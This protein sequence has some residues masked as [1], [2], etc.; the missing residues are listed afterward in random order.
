MFSGIGGFETALN[1]LGGNCV[2]ASEIDKHAQNNYE[3]IHG[4]KAQGDIKEVDARD[5]P[6]HELLTAGFPCQAFS[7]AGKRLGFQDARGTLFFEIARIAKEKRPRVLL[8]ENVKNLVGHDKGKTLNTMVQILSDIGYVVDF[9]VLNS[10]YFDVPQNRERVF[11]I[12]IREDLIETERW[13]IPKKRKDV[14]ARGKRRIRELEGIKSF[15]FDWPE[16]AKTTKRLRDILEK[17]VDEK[18]YLSKEKTE[19]LV[20]QLDEKKLPSHFPIPDDINK[21]LRTGGRGSLSAKHNY[22]HIAEPQMQMLGLLEMKGNECVRR[23][24]DING[25]SPTVSTCQGGHRE[26]KVAVK[27]SACKK[28]SFKLQIGQSSYL[29]YPVMSVKLQQ[30]SDGQGISHAIDA[31]YLKG[32]SPNDVGKGRRTHVIEE[33]KVEQ[34]GYIGENKQGNRVYNKDGI[35]VTISSNTGGQGGRGVNLVTEEVRATLTPEREEKRQNGRRFKEN[36]EPAFT[37]NTQDRHGITIGYRELTEKEVLNIAQKTRPGEKISVNF[38]ENGDIRPY[39]NDKK[40][41]GL[42]ELNINHE[43]NV[44]FTVSASHAPKTYGEATKYRIRKLTPLECF[45][46]QGFPDDHYWKLVEAGIKNSQLYKQ[47][48]NAVT[49]NVVEAIGKRLLNY[50]DSEKS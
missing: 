37:V 23:V 36:D 15:N 49:V 34:I 6:D 16:Q 25:I 44:S 22:E 27:Q 9:E 11:I 43:K 12:G 4:H 47:A 32:V 48:G 46:L 5:V 3:I 38:K 1:C 24:Y 29:S 41:S 50:L 30:F 14:V 13:E 39:R 19:K 17:N 35:G 28:C 42:G 21:T 2:F 10:K 7:V 40:K 45:R 20:S 26:P 31:N 33:N 18:Y 8:L